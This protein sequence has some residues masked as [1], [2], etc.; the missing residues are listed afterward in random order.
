[1]F[2]P[3]DEVC[4]DQKIAGETHLDNGSE[5]ELQAFLILRVALLAL[6][7]IGIQQRHAPSQPF[8][9]TFPQVLIECHARRRGELRQHA[10]SQLHAQRAAFGN[11][12]TV[13]QRFGN[14]GEQRRHFHPGFKILLLGK[15]ART[16]AIGQQC[17]FRDA[18]TRLMRL[19]I[20]AFGKLDGMG[21][22]HRQIQRQRQRQRGLQTVFSL[23]MAA[24]LD[25]QI[26]AIGK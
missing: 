8:L 22:H 10:F 24:A 17:A 9:G 21:S 2:G 18:D 6:G 3:V 25:F 13:G 11:F 26:I 19:E 12:Y 1:M 4:H 5:L 20:L 16:A 23:D 15:H 7:S 14:I